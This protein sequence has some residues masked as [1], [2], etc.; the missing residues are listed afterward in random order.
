LRLISLVHIIELSIA[1][2]FSVMFISLTIERFDLLH[3]GFLSYPLLTVI[4]II[5]ITVAIVFIYQKQF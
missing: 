1:L 5:P 4:L 2:T 3:F